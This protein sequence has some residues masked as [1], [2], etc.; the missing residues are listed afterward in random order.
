MEHQTQKYTNK[1]TTYIKIVA[2]SDNIV[3][4]SVNPP[5]GAQRSRVIIKSFIDVLNGLFLSNLAN[6]ANIN[7]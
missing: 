3:I 5:R 1:T 7:P 4:N 6:N 2:G